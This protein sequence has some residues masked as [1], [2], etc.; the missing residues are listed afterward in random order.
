M[1]AKHVVIFFIVISV[2]IGGLYFFQKKNQNKELVAQRIQQ[3]QNMTK[4]AEK[5]SSAGLLIMASAIN[6]FHKTKGQYPKTL[7][8]LYPEFIP[9]NSFISKLNWKYFPEKTTFLLQKSAEGGE[10]IAS[11]G[12][13]LRLKTQE[14]GSS[15]PEVMVAS[16]D[17]SKPLQPPEGKSVDPV[18]G[19]AEPDAKKTVENHQIAMN[20][21]QYPVK[22][23]KDMSSEKEEKPLISIVKKELNN[24]EKYLLSFSNSS[25]YI[26]KTKEG[27]VGFS[28]IQ[29]PDEKRL[30]IYRDQSWIEYIEE[31]DIH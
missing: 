27:A 8:E 5:S 16:T 31:S 24:N 12:P 21:H 7:L 13:D 25:F 3:L 2:I 14:K 28:N 6:K 1:E 11:M 22:T 19:K 18:L 30:T 26:W 23:S 20:S 9:D 10:T 17:K 29:Y 4:T 15:R